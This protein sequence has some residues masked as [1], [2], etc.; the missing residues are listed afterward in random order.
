MPKNKTFVRVASLSALIAGGL[1]AFQNCSKATF[2]KSESS[3]LEAPLCT[4]ISRSVSPVLDWDWQTQL[5]KADSPSFNQ[6]MASPTVADLDQDGHPEVVF[7]SWSPAGANYGGSGVLRVLDGATGAPKFSVSDPALVPFATTTPLLVDLDGDGKLEIVYLHGLRQKVIALNYDGKPR[8]SWTVPNGATFEYCFAGLSTADLDQNGRPEV[9]AGSF[10]LEEL[11]GQPVLKT[12]LSPAPPS[13]GCHVFATVLNPNKPQFSVV[14]PNAVYD[15]TGQRSF[16]LSPAG[17]YIAAGKVRPDLVG[18]QIVKTF[19]QHLYVYDGQSGQTLTDVDMAALSIGT[20]PAIANVRPAMIG[21]GPASIGDFT[22][23]GKLQIAVATGKNLLV[24][25]GRGNLVASSP[26]QDCSSM[27]TG[28][29]AFDF[30]GDGKP[31]IIYG[32]EQ[33]LRVYHVVNGK[34]EIISQIL[35]PTGTLLE[36]P[37]VADIKGDRSSRLL[38]VSN[39][40]AADSLYPAADPNLPAARAITGIRA[41]KSGDGLPWMPTRPS[42]GQYHFNA[43]LIDD[44]GHV[45]DPAISSQFYLGSTFKL[46]GILTTNQVRCRR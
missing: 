21:G 8:W 34:L 17:G 22:G 35:N 9:L 38:M 26:T 29:T 39:N 12:T 27:S 6:V 36:Y 11:N 42:W 33:Y 43:S 37:V 2:S 46:N 32:D 40:Y 19:N 7:V 24:F 28:V 15:N 16:P 20:C 10:V 31:E 23:D 41:F 45:S 18:S 44:R 1:I 5:S 4:D 30:D 3:S 25:D 13:N 14:D